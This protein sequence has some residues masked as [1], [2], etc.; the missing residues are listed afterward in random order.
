MAN[1]SLGARRSPC[2]GRW[3]VAFGLVTAALAPGACAQY[4][5]EDDPSAVD[6]CVACEPTLAG[7]QAI[8]ARSCSSPSCHGPG[9]PPSGLDLASDGV[10]QRLLSGG[11]VKPGDPDNSLLHQALANGSMPK[12]QRALCSAQLQCVHDWIAG[13][14]STDG[15][16][17]ANG[18]GADLATDPN[19]CG[20][21]GNVCPTGASCCGGACSETASDPA[22]C[23]SCGNACPSGQVC[24]NSACSAGCGSLTQCGSACVD[25]Q[26]SALN[27][28]GCGQACGAGQSCVDGDCA[29]PGGTSPCSNGCFDLTQDPNNCGACGNVCGAGTTCTASKCACAG[30]N[31]SFQSQVLPLFGS[32]ASP[33]C[34]GNIAP[35]EGLS[36]T[37]AN[38]Y[39][40]LVNVTASQCNGTK[41]RVLPGD[42]SQSYL[43]NKLTGIGT[44]FG[45]KMPK[46]PAAALSQA[47]IDTISQ[48]ICSGAPNN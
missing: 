43:I 27:C 42:P 5:T 29:C 2:F 20:S 9:N 11:Y 17:D 19:N 45:T 12:G 44:C 10:D 38:A 18:C 25:T 4:F 40:N 33:T 46:P 7:M 22:H 3:L 36:L 13:L 47:Q 34:H 30:G 41:K 39:G 6:T 24:L 8:F 35:K 14:G 48:W 15:G 16:S 1:S 31:V 28:G 26:T 21:C 37:A 23:G 32:C